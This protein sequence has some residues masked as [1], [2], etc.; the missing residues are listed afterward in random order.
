[1]KQELQDSRKK[2]QQLERDNEHLKKSLMRSELIQKRAEKEAKALRENRGKILR[3]LNTQTEIALVQFKRDFENLKRQMQTKDEIIHA[4]DRKIKS[5]NETNCSLRNGLQ[6]KT[7]RVS[8]DSERST[9][10]DDDE[11]FLPNGHSMHFHTE[12]SRFIRELDSGR[13]N[14]FE[15]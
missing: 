8:Q 3:G 13:F 7:S 11:E 4:Q 14:E 6:R 5:L 10:D 1:M 9:D 2:L 15:L 12:L